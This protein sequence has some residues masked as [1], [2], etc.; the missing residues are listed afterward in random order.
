MLDQAEG[1]DAYAPVNYR[2]GEFLHPRNLGAIWKGR[3]CTD[4]HGVN[5][6]DTPP[7]II[8]TTSAAE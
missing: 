3:N 4:C 2:G 7:E 8:T 1:E 6:D 5:V